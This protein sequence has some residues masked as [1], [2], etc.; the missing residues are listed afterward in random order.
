MNL[1][2]LLHSS[3][4]N[5]FYKGSART[6]RQAIVRTSNSRIWSSNKTR[7]SSPFFVD[8]SGNFTLLGGVRPVVVLVVTAL[9]GLVFLD[10]VLRLDMIDPIS[11][12][13]HDVHLNTPHFTHDTQP[14]TQP[15][16]VT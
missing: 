4:E 2:N 15:L 8:S 11:D 1:T 5:K 14:H 7:H 16:D 3:V 13:Y 6:S 9:T 10:V 12:V